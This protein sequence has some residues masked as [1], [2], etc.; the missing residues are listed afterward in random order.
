MVRVLGGAG[1]RRAKPMPPA[2]TGLQAA[3]QRLP[4]EPKTLR[5]VPTMVSIALLLGVMVGLLL[6]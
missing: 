4:P 6:P 2:S 5:L 3:R 1:K